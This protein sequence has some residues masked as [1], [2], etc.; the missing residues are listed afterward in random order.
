MNAFIAD[1]FDGYK[2]L[3]GQETIREEEGAPTDTEMILRVFDMDG[4]FNSGEEERLNRA[5]TAVVGSW[6]Q[7]GGMILP[8]IAPMIDR[9]IVALKGE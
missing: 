2:C 1:G 5:R 4:N 7:E 3:E 6:Q 8:V 9:R